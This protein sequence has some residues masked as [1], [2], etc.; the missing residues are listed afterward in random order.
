MEKLQYKATKF[1]LKASGE[2]MIE[3]YAA[4]FGNIDSYGDII[5]QGA[6]T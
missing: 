2:N 6:F 3:G 4:F 5:E 1:E